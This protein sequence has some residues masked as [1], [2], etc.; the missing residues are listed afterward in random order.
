M[1]PI[2]EDSQG[3]VGKFVKILFILFPNGSPSK[4]FIKFPAIQHNLIKLVIKW[5]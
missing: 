4:S 3:V 1:P 2:I 5:Y